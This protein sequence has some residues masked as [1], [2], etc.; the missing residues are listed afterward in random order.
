MGRAILGVIVGYIVMAGAVLGSFAAAWMVF[1]QD[2]AYKE[3]LWEISTTWMIMMFVAGLI[4]AM[5]GGAVCAAIAAKGSKAAMVLAG[6]V[7]VLGFVDAGFKLAA[8]REDRPTAR[9]D[10]VTMFEA[11]QSSQEPTVMLLGNPVIGLVGVLIGARLV[12]R[13]RAAAVG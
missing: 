9:E 10:N 6:L 8:P 11:T 7:L 3:G 1:G 12:G 5:I 13:K 4:A 2:S